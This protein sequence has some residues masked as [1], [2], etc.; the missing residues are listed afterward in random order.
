[1]FRCIYKLSTA[2][3]ILPEDASKNQYLL[4]QH[5]KTYF[6]PHSGVSHMLFLTLMLTM[7][8]KHFNFIADLV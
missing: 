5:E 3:S 4:Q 6:N 1:M 2:T 7:Q 8:P